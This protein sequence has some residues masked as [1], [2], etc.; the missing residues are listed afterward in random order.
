[1]TCGV[2]DGLLEGAVAIA[3]KYAYRAITSLT[4]QIRYHQVALSVA[5]YIGNGH[6]TGRL[7]SR[8]VGHNRLEGA[9]A[10]SQQDTHHSLRGR[11]TVPTSKGP[12]AYTITRHDI[13][14]P[15]AV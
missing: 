1:M 10:V 13:K 3:Q 2:T 8:V 14:L 15:V 7:S 11:T 4:I 9:V 12:S 5:V 6:R